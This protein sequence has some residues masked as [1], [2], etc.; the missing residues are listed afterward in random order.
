MAVY[1]SAFTSFGT[2]SPYLYLERGRSEGTARYKLSVEN[3][4]A[5]VRYVV[6]RSGPLD[7]KGNPT[8]LPLTGYDLQFG[9]TQ[10]VLG[11][12]EIDSGGQFP[13]IQRQ[14]PLA[15]PIY[16]DWYAASVEQ[17]QG[18][19]NL[20]GNT[21]FGLDP[22]VYP[23]TAEEANTPLLPLSLRSQAG[24]LVSPS[25]ALANPQIE[26]VSLPA[27]YQYPIYEFDVK[28]TPRPYW[29][30]TDTS[31]CIAAVNLTYY[32]AGLNA[33]GNYSATETVATE[34]NRFVDVRFE[35][36]SQFYSVEGNA[37]QF[38]T[39]N[40]S[41]GPGLPA[42]RNNTPLMG[43]IPFRVPMQKV[44]FLWYNVPYNY[45]T[46]QYSRLAWYRGRIN[47]F[48]FMGFTQGSLLYDS[49]TVVSYSQPNASLAGYGN[50]GNANIAG[51]YVQIS[52]PPPD[53]EGGYVQAQGDP[54]ELARG[55]PPL[56]LKPKLCN[57]DLV[58]L[59]T[60]RQ[61]SNPPAA[62]TNPNF[63]MA[64]HNLLPHWYDKRYYYAALNSTPA[65]PPFYSFPVELLFTNPDFLKA[66]PAG[67]M[68]W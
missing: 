51:G 8:P 7:A 15:H 2:P 53:G 31:P 13:M 60:N 5:F 3:A 40:T 50:V 58:F 24:L 4:E 11:Y 52:G 17:V 54:F 35:D 61:I 62:P 27:W 64:G 56:S 18:R 6:F 32:T 33:A 39:G 22:T 26:G 45:V 28:F 21:V 38:V 46:S 59:H 42:S 57:L 43:K 12:T 34:W 66:M 65:Q 23:Q 36:A 67:D 16:T 30:L 14:L 20:S 25:I 10:D 49:Y 48:G 37:Y 47:Q 9:V 29:L 68:V 44:H 55:N 63:L 41:P 19:G 1:P